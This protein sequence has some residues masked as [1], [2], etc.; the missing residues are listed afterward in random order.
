MSETIYR[1]VEATGGGWLEPIGVPKNEPV[2]QIPIVRQSFK[3]MAVASVDIETDDPHLKQWGPGACRHDGKILGIGCY[4]PDKGIDGYFSPNEYNEALAILAD[5]DVV[6]VLG[7]IK[8]FKNF[9]GVFL[10]LGGCYQKM[11]ALSL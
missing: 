9:Y 1:E 11:F 7:K 6:K 5:A 3:G 8:V 2:K 10:W 4:C